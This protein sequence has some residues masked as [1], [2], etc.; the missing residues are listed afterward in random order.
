[1]RIG[2]DSAIALSDDGGKIGCFRKSEESDGD[3]AEHAYPSPE[4]SHRSP[5]IGSARFQIS[6]PHQI[7]AD[8]TKPQYG[9]PVDEDP[10]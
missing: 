1:L 2:I 10:S 8:G 7:A 5:T 3:L 9:T 6:V 4:R